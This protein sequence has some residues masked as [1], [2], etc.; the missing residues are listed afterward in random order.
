[1]L[2]ARHCANTES[3]LWRSSTRWL[4]LVVSGELLVVVNNGAYVHSQV[5]YEACHID[6]LHDYSIDP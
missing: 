1:M 2:L 5:D 6:G 3:E 4:R